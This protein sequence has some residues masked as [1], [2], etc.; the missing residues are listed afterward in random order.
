MIKLLTAL[1]ISLTL[2]NGPMV[3]YALEWKQ[4]HEKA[5]TMSVAQV[6]AALAARPSDISD[7]FMRQ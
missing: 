7:L 2:L 4:L 3:A 5:E 1:G 6:E